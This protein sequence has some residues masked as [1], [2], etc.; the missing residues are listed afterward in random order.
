M[1][2]N[3]I[4][5]DV[6]GYLFLFPVIGLISFIFISPLIRIVWYSFVKWNF[7]KITKNPTL[8]NYVDVITYR[9]FPT[10]L[11]NNFLIILVTI[12]VVIILAVIIAHFMYSKILGAKF[13]QFLFFI[14]VVIPDI[15]V[16]I[17]WSFFLH[18]HGP[19]NKILNILHLSFLQ[20]DW[21]GNPAS[22]LWGL[23]IVL[24]WREIG[25]A[26]ILFISRMTTIDPFLYE[27]AEVDGANDFKK[28]IHIT[29]PQLRGVISI[30]VI[31]A[32]IA[33]MNKLF[34]FVYIMTGGGPGHSSNVLEYY[35]YYSGFILRRFG[36]ANAIAVILFLLT[37]FFIFVF[38]KFF[39][40]EKGI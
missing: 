39:K 6:K 31:L 13:Y 14:P 29:I 23:I 36:Q 37:M 2:I 15:V 7:F 3:T 38:I 5:N 10:I 33:F 20:V 24:I 9:H 8:N 16:G 21:F 19:V 22:S 32:I 40:I 34:S 35:I 11:R 4:E 17:I 25:F 26:M 27:A 30:Y 28:L 12:P 1:K 18:I